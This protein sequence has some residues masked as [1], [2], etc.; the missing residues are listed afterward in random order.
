MGYHTGVRAK[1]RMMS[2]GKTGKRKRPCF[3]VRRQGRK[4]SA[5]LVEHAVASQLHPCMFWL[6]MF[7]H[8]CVVILGVAQTTSS[9]VGLNLIPFHARV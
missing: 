9:V 6:E 4:P 8:I 1:Y 5:F 7:C 2:F 3:S